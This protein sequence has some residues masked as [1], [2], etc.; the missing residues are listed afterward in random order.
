MPYRWD[1]L[2]QADAAWVYVRTD[3]P[4]MDD[5]I[6][7]NCRAILIREA[8]GRVASVDRTAFHWAKHLYRPVVIGRFSSP[9][10][11][12]CVVRAHVLTRDPKHPHDRSCRPARR[13]REPIL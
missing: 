5:S 4:G 6:K 7:Q 9:D 13:E 11:A 12:V 3:R 10:D 2:D 8:D 1:S